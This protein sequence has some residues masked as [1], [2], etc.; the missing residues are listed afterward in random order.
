MTKAELV[1]KMAE[2]AN[3]SKANAE[4]ALNAFL[5]TVKEA[6]AQGD[7]ISLVGFGTF[8]VAERSSREG[9]NPK[10]GEKLTIPACKVVKFKPGNMLR[11]AVK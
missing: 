2:K 1:S 4:K 7:K 10:T 6:L 9:R 5:E 8:S 3:I 11:D